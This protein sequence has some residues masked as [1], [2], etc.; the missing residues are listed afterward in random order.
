MISV[1]FVFPHSLALHFKSRCKKNR[2]KLCS[3]YYVSQV[4]RICKEMPYRDLILFSTVRKGV[5]MRLYY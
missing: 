2:T 5:Y 4:L 1:C 3:A